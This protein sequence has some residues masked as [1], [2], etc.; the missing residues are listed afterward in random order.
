VKSL[1]NRLNKRV[2]I[3]SLS[4]TTDGYGQPQDIW[5]TVATVWAAVE[6]LSGS[7][8]FAARKLHAEVTTKLTI[9]YRTGIDRTMR[10]LVNSKTFEIMYV[11]NVNEANRELQL[12]CKE[13]Q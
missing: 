2:T 8:F 6:T 3:K 13:L 5:S 10:A 4:T 12:F 1:V 7:E 11:I 9:R